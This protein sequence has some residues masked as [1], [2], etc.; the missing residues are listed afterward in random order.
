MSSNT[1]SQGPAPLLNRSF[2]RLERRFYRLLAWHG[3]ADVVLVLVLAVLVS[4]LLDYV[5]EMPW[6]L[7]LLF[8]V[9][10]AA[11]WAVVLLRGH[12]RSRRRVSAAELLAT[13][14]NADPELEGQ[15]ANAVELRRTMARRGRSPE[16]GEVTRSELQDELLRRAVRESQHILPR[17]DVERALDR[18]HG[19]P[20]RWRATAPRC[21]VGCGSRAA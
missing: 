12:R 14:E 1:P 13:V 5:F 9:V 17:V 15:L 21:V 4:F 6:A 16:E 18:S 3:L 19:R 8:L 2:V 11:L 20:R 7:R 10:V